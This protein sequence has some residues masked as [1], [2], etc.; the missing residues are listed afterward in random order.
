MALESK[1]D[2]AKLRQLIEENKSATEIMAAFD[3]K[4]PVLK[5]FMTKLMMQDEKFYKI[6]GMDVR[7][8]SGTRKVSKLGIHLS[9]TML[10]KLGFA[11]GDTLFVSVP[12][13]GKLMLVKQV[14]EETS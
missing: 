3:I 4:K 5:T 7:T 9:L 13:T 11:H 14:A 1:Y 6:V 2:A 10:N 8:S 12:E